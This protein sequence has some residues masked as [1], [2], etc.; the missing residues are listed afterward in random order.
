MPIDDRVKREG[1]GTTST[2]LA[3]STWKDKPYGVLAK[4]D[5][6]MVYRYD[7]FQ[8]QGLKLP[9]TW[10]SLRQARPPN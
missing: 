8:K 10:T 1:V 4:M 5:R 7:L 6:L 2:P 9:E 3:T